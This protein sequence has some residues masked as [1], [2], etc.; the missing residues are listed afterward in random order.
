M[1]RLLVIEMDGTGEKMND[2]KPV[3]AFTQTAPMYSTK[4]LHGHS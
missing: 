3:Y 2:E 4:Q 1:Q